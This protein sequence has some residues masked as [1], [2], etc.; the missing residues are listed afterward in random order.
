MLDSKISIFSFGCFVSF[1]FI[2]EQI[3]FFVYEKQMCKGSP[4]AS[5][6]SKRYCLFKATF[7]FR[8]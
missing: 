2:Y 5:G 6:G 4:E 3:N 1:H 7:F 8:E